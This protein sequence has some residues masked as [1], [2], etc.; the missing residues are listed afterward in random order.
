MKNHRT[1]PRFR[2]LSLIFVFLILAAQAILIPSQQAAAA[3]IV[4]RSLTLEANA[5]GGSKSG[6]VVNHFFAF[7]LPGGS[8]VGSIK[9][10]YCETAAD[11][12]PATCV[13]PT[14]LV[15]T[16]ATLANESGV[17]GFTMNNT[18]NG[19]PFIYKTP[20]A[21]GTNVDVTYRLQTITNPVYGATV[22]DTNKT[23]FV[24]ITT[25]ATNNAT[26]APTDA[27]VVAA[28]T[29]EPIIL[30][31]IMPESLVF[32]TGA[33]ITTTASVPDCST[34]TSGVISFNQ[35]FSPTSTASA[36]S[37]MSATTN[38][39]SGYA[40]TVNGP[41]L[42]SGT[43]TITAIAAPSASI[44][45]IAQFGL[46]LRANTAAAAPGFPGVSPLDSADITAGSNGT[47]LNGRPTA[48]YATPD[49]FKFAS[50]DVV[51]DSN[52][53][54][55]GS[56]EPSDAQIFTVSYIANVPG[57]QPAGTY[58]TTLTYICTA[59]F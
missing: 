11:V 12:S 51:A 33:D 29:A 2:A 49:T 36:I 18:T 53:N 40:I 42:T 28:S 32:C 31:G 35:L 3:Q 30:S 4:N 58:T 56:P 59:T 23:F 25:Y 37:R 50:G 8:T 5:A 44:K 7:R 47:N 6:G 17:T 10:Q 19:A 45:G 46:N 27:G 39:G 43:N 26:G 20:A 48:D 14:G 24:R 52:Y 21:I 34:A 57:S 38:A 22:P 9:F 54:T 16:S 41:T 1:T 13:T 55:T 15:T